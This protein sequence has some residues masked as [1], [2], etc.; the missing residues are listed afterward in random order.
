MTKEERLEALAWLVEQ[1]E[2]VT[3]G[4]AGIDFGA[5]KIEVNRSPEVLLFGEGFSELARAA[6]QVVQTEKTPTGNTIEYFMFD[7]VKFYDYVSGEDDG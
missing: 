2:A 6:S 7:G 5:S 3:N 1:T 4:I